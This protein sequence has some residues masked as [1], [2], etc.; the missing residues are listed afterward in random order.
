MFFTPD[1]EICEQCL[2]EEPFPSKLVFAQNQPELQEMTIRRGLRERIDKVL[3]SWRRHTAATRCL[4]HF[5][6]RHRMLDIE[7]EDALQSRGW[8]TELRQ[9]LLENSTQ[10][11]T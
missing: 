4:E 11:V 9:R 7:V 6:H 2:F 10:P 5:K 1:C 3:C 8:W